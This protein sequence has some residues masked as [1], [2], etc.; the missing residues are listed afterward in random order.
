MDE[1]R[2]SNQV[3]LMSNSLFIFLSF[4]A[5]LAFGYISIVRLLVKRE[6]GVLGKLSLVNS[7]KNTRI[8][9]SLGSSAF[10]VSMPATS[11]LLFWGWGPALL[12]LLT[13]H[14]FIESLFHLQ[15]T[16]TEQELSLAELLIRSNGSKLAHLESVLVQGFFIIL[17]ATMITLLATLIDEQS[18]LLFT[19]LALFP[20]QQLLRNRNGNVPFSL[21]II[22]SIVV[23]AIGIMFAHRLG[24]S[25]YG[26]WAPLQSFFGNSMAWLAINNVTLIAGILIITSFLLAKKGQF[27]TDV[28]T[29]SGAAITLLIIAMQIRLA[30][31]QPSLDAPLNAA[32]TSEHDLPLFIGFCLFSFAGISALLIRLLNDET[33]YADAQTSAICFS[34]LQLESVVQLIFSMLLVLSLAAALGIGAWKTHYVQWSDGASFVGHMSLAIKGTLQLVSSSFKIGTFAHTVIM[35]CMCIAGISFSMMCVSRFKITRHSRDDDGSLYDVIMSAKLPQALIIFVLTCYFIAYGISITTWLI[36]GMLSWALIVHLMLAITVDMPDDAQSR[37][38]YGLVCLFLMIAG[39]LQIL[40]LSIGWLIDGAYLAS[41]ISAV[42]LLSVWILWWQ[43][44][45]EISKRFAGIGAPK[46]LD[47]D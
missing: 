40:G 5:F 23:F 14:I 15:Y 41:G 10:F 25:V 9:T 11:L 19:L 6:F 17:M 22:G 46:Q 43:G 12:W 47:I 8:L 4:I 33:N 7:V 42:I 18:G 13:F 3:N 34:R 31:S 30:I 35:A 26:E 1:T 39:S 24:F 28:A 20:A 2:V 32:Q 29:F 38:T 37:L 27:Q 44:A 45:L 16:T 36:A 21:N